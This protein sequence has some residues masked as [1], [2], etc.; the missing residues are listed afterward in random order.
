MITLRPFEASDSDAVLQ[1]HRRTEAFDGVPRV[2]EAD[3]L[4]ED[5]DDDSVRWGTDTRVAR[6]D[7]VV[8]YA[9]FLP[10]CGQ[11]ASLLRSRRRTRR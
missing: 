7:E 11:A 6:W 8:G 5:L 2:F 3:E 1:A 4:S 9:L 10:Q